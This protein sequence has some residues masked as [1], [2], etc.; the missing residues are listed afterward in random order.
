VMD[1]PHFFKTRA[2]FIQTIHNMHT[3]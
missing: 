2:A 1:Y 3:S